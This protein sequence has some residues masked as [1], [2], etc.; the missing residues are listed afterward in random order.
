MKRHAART[1]T[2]LGRHGLRRHGKR[3]P[4]FKSARGD[5]PLRVTCAGTPSARA[6]CNREIMATI[7]RAEP[8]TPSIEECDFLVVGS[9]IAGLSYAL[10]VAESGRVA[11]VTKDVASEGS[12]R[13]AQGGICA[14]LDPL[15]SVDSH[16]QDTMVAGDF[17]CDETVVKLVCTEGANAVLDLVS[18]GAD[19]DRTATGSLHLTREGGHEHNRIVHAADLTGAEIERTLLEK[20]RDNP[21]ITMYENFFATELVTE[22]VGPQLYCM[23]CDTF[24]RISGRE[25]RF[26]ALS[27]MLASGGSGHL[28]PSTTNPGVSTGDGIAMAARAGAKVSN[29]EFMQ[30]HPT[31]FAA[32]PI[33]GGPASAPSLK[34][35]AVFLI[36]EAVRGEGGLLFNGDGE[37]FMPQYDDR[38]ELA[39]RDVVAR[40]IDHQCKQRGEEHAYL[41]ISHKSSDML[42]KHFPNISAECLKHGIDITQDPIPVTPAMHYTCGGITTGLHAETNIAGLFACGEAACTGLHGANRLASNSLLEGLVFGRKASDAAVAHAETVSRAAELPWSRSALTQKVH[43]PYVSRTMDPAREDSV[44]FNLL[45]LRRDLQDVMWDHAGIVR[46]TQ[47]LKQGL[48]RLKQIGAKVCDICVRGLTAELSAEWYEVANLLTV[49]ELVT[50]SAL[51]RRE[52]RGLHYTLDYPLKVESERHPTS[53]PSTLRLASRLDLVHAKKMYR[54]VQLSKTPSP[55]IK[56]ESA[57]LVRK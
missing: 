57:E 6:G 14:V 2:S 34:R 15:D 31:S 40:A 25:V 12:T 19:F 52:S 41:D 35:E 50:T 39:P 10:K 13:Y 9:G 4:A 32:P 21:N 43:R 45:S 44:R 54:S 46:N 22:Q 55:K 48:V 37:R 16:A 27:T 26:L 53:I 51:M 38:L 30:F 28:Y 36:S 29:M 7:L 1:S 23:G 47:G 18:M 3:G 20:V 56:A 17:L 33:P 11:I 8:E 42:L 5:N 24:D 49:A